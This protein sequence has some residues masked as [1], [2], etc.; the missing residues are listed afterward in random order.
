MLILKAK[1]LDAR[2]LPAREPYPPS[3]LVSVLSGTETLHLMANHEVLEELA[4]LEEFTEVAFELRSKQLR[5]ES[6]GGSGK[7]NAYRL[8][9]R[10]LL[11]PEEIA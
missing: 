3:C 2:E 7:G 1:Y 9:I 8:S 10:R 11:V 5:L 4:Q 6:F